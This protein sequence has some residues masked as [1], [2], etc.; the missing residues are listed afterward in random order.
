MP[1]RFFRMQ[2]QQLQTWIHERCSI[3]NVEN[4]FVNVRGNHLG[5]DGGG[6]FFHYSFIAQTFHFPFSINRGPPYSENHTTPRVPLLPF[7]SSSYS[8]FSFFILSLDILGIFA[9][10]SKLASS[11]IL[12]E[13]FLLY[14]GGLAHLSQ[15]S[16]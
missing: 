5:V 13:K 3:L 15:I 10:K 7:C 1:Q 16:H 14:P 11:E 12:T 9:L 2:F 6:R 8:L 4:H